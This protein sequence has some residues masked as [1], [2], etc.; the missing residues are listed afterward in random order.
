VGRKSVEISVKVADINVRMRDSLRAVDKDR[1]TMAVGNLNHLLDRIDSAKHVG[2]L[3]DGKKASVVGEHIVELIEHKLTFGIHRDDMKDDTLVALDELPRNN[4]G[5]MLH[6]SDD[7]VVAVKESV[8]ERRSH[9]IDGFSGAT[10]ENNLIGGFSVDE[11]TNL[12]AR[13]LHKV[14]GFLREGVHTTMNVGLAGMIDIV[15]TIHNRLRS[16]SSGRIVKIN[17]RLPID[18]S[19]ENRKLATNFSYI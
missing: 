9:K 3:T 16:L 17:E 12:F 5:M 7:N 2:N 11:G 13:L 10:G 8:A 4:I 6:D 14:G 1:N 18:L 15:D 19:G